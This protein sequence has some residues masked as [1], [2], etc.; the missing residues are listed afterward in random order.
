M[1]GKYQKKSVKKPRVN[2]VSKAKTKVKSVSKAKPK[3][4]SVKKAKTKIK[5]VSK[6]KPKG[7]SVS[8]S[9]SG[10]VEQFTKKYQE[11][12]SPAYPANKCCGESKRGKDGLMYESRADKNGVCTWKK[13][14]NHSGVRKRHQEP[15]NAERFIAKYNH[16]ISEIE[17]KLVHQETRY[18]YGRLAYLKKQ[19]TRLLD[20]AVDDMPLEPLGLER[21]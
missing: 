8:K 12:P 9:D 11:R 14:K 13:V 16:E 3:L 17:R 1:L 20:R 21:Q 15:F 4:K 2:S 10:C 6:A 19:V 7:K 18:L 5:S